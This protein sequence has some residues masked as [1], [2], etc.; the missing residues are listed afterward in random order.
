MKRNKGTKPN[1]FRRK[2]GEIEEF[3]LLFR[4]SFFSSDVQYVIEY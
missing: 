3:F 1:E 2:V 4:N